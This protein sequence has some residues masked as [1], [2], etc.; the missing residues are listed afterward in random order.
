[1]RITAEQRRQNE[2]RIRAAMDRLLRG[3]IPAGG[4]C[5]VQTLAAEAQVAR[6]AFYSG[7]PYEHLRNEFERRLAALRESGAIPDPR[8]AQIARLKESIAKLKE[9]LA[10]SEAKETEHD[11]F[12]ELA[13]SRLAAQH[14]EIERLRE[15]LN[16]SGAVLPL[17]GRVPGQK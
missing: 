6:A 7:R 15:L 3:E 5:D 2:D 9:R 17:V 4:R 8:D 1:M 12:R 14:D 13:L 11:S 10:V 16:V